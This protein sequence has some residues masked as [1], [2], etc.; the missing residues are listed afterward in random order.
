MFWVNLAVRYA[1]IGLRAYLL[2]RRQ[3]GE[4]ASRQEFERI[5]TAELT[6]LVKREL[7]H[8]R[9]RFPKVTGNLRRSIRVEPGGYRYIRLYADP[10]IAPHQHLVRFK[11]PMHRARTVREAF[12]AYLR[13]ARFKRLIQAALDYTV[14]QLR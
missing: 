8:I 10:R 5:F 7:P 3:R 13:S 2:L 1:L 11:K 9:T 6:R 4:R 14:S 12:D